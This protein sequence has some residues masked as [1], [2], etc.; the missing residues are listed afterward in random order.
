MTPR[1]LGVHSAGAHSPPFNT[2][3]TRSGHFAASSVLA[4]EPV[5]VV[6]ELGGLD[7]SFVNA[8]KECRPVYIPFDQKCRATWRHGEKGRTARNQ[9]NR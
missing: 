6:L 8:N 3:D 7:V 2:R 5:G 9:K 4:P 1:R